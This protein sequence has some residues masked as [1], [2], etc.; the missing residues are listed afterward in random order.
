MIRALLLAAFAIGT[1]QPAVAQSNEQLLP[2]G[3]EKE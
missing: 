1:I 3:P 2:A